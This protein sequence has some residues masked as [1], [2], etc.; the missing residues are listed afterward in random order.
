[1][2]M[3]VEFSFEFTVHTRFEAVLGLPSFSFHP[4]ISRFKDFERFVDLFA[5]KIKT[6]FS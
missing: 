3:T 2:L 6:L 4:A 1:M 5:G